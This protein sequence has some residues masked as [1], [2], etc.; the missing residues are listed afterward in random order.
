MRTMARLLTLLLLAA[1]CGGRAFAADRNWEGGGRS[2]RA[3]DR[4]NW[5]YGRLPGPSD[6]VVFDR[7]S[8]RDCAWDLETEVAA[9]TV[10]EGFRG[11][12]RFEAPLKVSGDMDVEGGVLHLKGPSLTVGRRLYIGVK[13]VFDLLDGT[14][15]LGRRGLVVDGYFFSRGNAKAHIEAA[16]PGEYFDFSVK[17]GNL[18]VTNPAGTELNGSGGIKVARGARVM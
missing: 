18:V 16:V 14:L 10:S 5:A 3:S 17:R 4:D 2:G 7:R 12:V 9:F 15:R 8:S 11:D 6:R 13:G 1:A